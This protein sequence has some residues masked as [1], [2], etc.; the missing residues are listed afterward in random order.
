MTRAHAKLICF[1]VLSLV[2]RLLQ[3]FAGMR[4][5]NW[6]RYMEPEAMGAIMPPRSYFSLFT[7]LAASV[8]YDLHFFFERFYDLHFSMWGSLFCFS[9][10]LIFLL[11]FP[12]FPL[13]GVIFF[14]GLQFILFE[15]SRAMQKSCTSCVSSASVNWNKLS[16]ELTMISDFRMGYPCSGCGF[17]KLLGTCMRAWGRANVEMFYGSI[18]WELVLAFGV[19]W[20]G[21]V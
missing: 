18:C 15:F 3:S 9:S 1:L 8:C 7:P 14:I 11:F 6:H 21:E 2:T 20:P 10:I 19:A 4:E 12:C 16:A 5:T 17:A 13:H